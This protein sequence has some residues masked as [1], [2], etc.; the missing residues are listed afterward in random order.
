MKLLILAILVFGLVG[1][2]HIAP[3][4]TE[5]YGSTL[6]PVE[7]E[8]VFDICKPRRG[9]QQEPEVRVH[10]HAYNSMEYNCI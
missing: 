6:V 7:E 8:V 1:C 10:G 5:D 3:V 2:K 9:E 4:A